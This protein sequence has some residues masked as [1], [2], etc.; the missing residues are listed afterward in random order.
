MAAGAGV[1]QAEAEEDNARALLDFDVIC[2]FKVSSNCLC[3][4]EN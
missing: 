4:S 2:D 3:R 1:E